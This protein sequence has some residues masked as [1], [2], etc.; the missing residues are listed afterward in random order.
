M[1]AVQKFQT[2]LERLF[3]FDASDLDFGIYRILNFKRNQIRK[4]IHEDLKD[5]VEKVFAVHK[6]ERLDNIGLQLED[7]KQKV[8]QTLGPGAISTTGELKGLP[9]H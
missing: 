1:D 7:A 9:L 6:D 3:Q 8:I 2:L 4:F 5:T